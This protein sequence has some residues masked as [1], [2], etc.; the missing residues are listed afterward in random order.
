VPYTC[1]C[2]CE[3]GLCHTH[4]FVCVKQV[5][6]LK[7]NYFEL[8]RIRPRLQRLKECLEE[9]PYSGETS[10]VD[11]ATHRVMALL[12]VCGLTLLHSSVMPV[13]L[14]VHLSACLSVR[15]SVCLN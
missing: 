1:V 3:A 2:V 6:A 14:S 5:C 13:C 12:T 15:L 11:C 4:V 10:E 7:K 9:A 8:R